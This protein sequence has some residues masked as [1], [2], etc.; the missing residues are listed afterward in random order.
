MLL[1][2]GSVR[3]DRQALVLVDITIAGR[4]SMRNQGTCVGHKTFI[5]I[6]ILRKIL[7]QEYINFVRFF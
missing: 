2:P 7:K 6:F 5:N 1:I 4:T 3:H